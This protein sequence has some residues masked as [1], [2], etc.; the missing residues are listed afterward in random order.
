MKLRVAMLSRWHVH[1]QGYAQTL[2]GWEDV[3]ITRVWDEDPEAGEAWAGELGVPYEADLEVLL[4]RQDVDAVVVD[5]PT[6]MHA[7]VICAAARAGKAIF[8][9]KVLAAT[10]EEAMEI[11]RAMEQAGVVFCIS[12][13]QR[14]TRQIGCIKAEL[15]R[16]T[17]GTVSLLR[18]RDAHGGKSQNWLPERWYDRAA[19]CG[20]AMMDLGAHP[21][22]LALYLLGK[23]ETVSASFTSIQTP[24]DYEDNAVS[25]CTY[26]TGALAVLETG[27]LTPASPRTLEIHGTEASMWMEEGRVWMRKA[28][29]KASV[30]MDP[31]K[32]PEAPPV[33]LRMWIDAATKGKP[34]LFGIEEAVALT[35]MMEAA[36]RSA[37][38]RQPVALKQ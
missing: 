15:D 26:P 5:T 30:E 24:G 36:Y 10:R 23:P 25:V 28:G 14:A 20:G 22:Y 12:Y 27:F 6:S 8:T 7:A 31:E 1:A 4:A 21:N 13:P 2:Q 19:T 11:R 18:I 3:E 34:M 33:P 35:E 32:M 29:E 9:E 37:R 16:G 38:E 17:L